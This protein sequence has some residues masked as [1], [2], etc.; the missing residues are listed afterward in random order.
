MPRVRDKAAG[1]PSSE[2]LPAEGTK[3]ATSGE[4]ACDPGNCCT[5][6]VGPGRWEQLAH[7][8]LISRAA[9]VQVPLAGLPLSLQTR[10]QGDCQSAY[11]AVFGSADGRPMPD[12]GPGLFPAVAATLPHSGA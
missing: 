2:K 12:A 11:A 4:G 6:G 9:L 3:K 7:E 1:R 8:L 10:S 5:G